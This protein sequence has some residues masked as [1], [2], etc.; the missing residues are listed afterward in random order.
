MIRCLFKVEATCLLRGRDLVLVPGIIS[1]GE[2]RFRVGDPVILRRPDGSSVEAKISTLEFPNPNPRH[3]I[4]IGIAGLTKSDVPIGT[5][6]W[7][8]DGPAA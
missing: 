5:E 6:V 3:T 2:E 4:P 1:E 7:S 8:V